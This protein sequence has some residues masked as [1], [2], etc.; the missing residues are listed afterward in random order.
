MDILDATNPQK[1]IDDAAKQ[2]DPPVAPSNAP[3][4]P[5]PTPPELPKTEE[6]PKLK[7]EALLPQKTEPDPVP[8]VAPTPAPDIPIPPPMPP[9]PVPDIKPAEPLQSTTFGAPLPK[10]PEHP[11]P[12]PPP[13]KK[14]GMGKGVILA[15]LLLLLVALPIGVY[16]VSQQQKQ[17]TEQRSKAAGASCGWCANQPQCPHA[18]EASKVGVCGGLDCCQGYNAGGAA[19]APGGGGGGG[20]GSTNPTPINGESCGWCAGNDQCYSST[21]HAATKV[22]NAA[23]CSTGYC[24]TGYTPPTS[25]T[26]STGGTGGGTTCTPGQVYCQSSYSSPAAFSATTHCDQSQN[27][28]WGARCSANGTF[29]GSPGAGVIC[30]GYD[31]CAPSTSGTCAG[32]VKL[33]GGYDQTSTGGFVG[34]S[35]Q[36]DCF[37]GTSTPGTSDSYGTGHVYTSSDGTVHCNTDTPPLSC[38]ANALPVTAAATPAPSGCKSDWCTSSSDCASKGGTVGTPASFASCSPGLVACCGVA[39]QQQNTPAPTP[40]PPGQCTRIK[41]YKGTVAVAPTTLVPGDNVTLAVAGTNATKGRIRV[42]GAAF[43][44]ST[45]LNANGEYTVPFT[46][47][48]GVPQFTIEAEVF[49][50]GQWQ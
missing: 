7:E 11:L 28:M 37:C 32:K 17:I 21:G 15:G 25:G 12:S 44:E 29:Q 47:P 27:S 20:G 23:V 9:I 36:Q 4:P 35:G 31:A 6:P 42:N 34:C 13:A 49:T 39:I 16:Y 19:P 50:N 18:P 41:V 26:G 3:P 43:V 22:I 33:S 10:E 45:T 14:G 30:N 8:P 1:L 40:P 46:V 48:S 5:S 38:A 24:C 2:I